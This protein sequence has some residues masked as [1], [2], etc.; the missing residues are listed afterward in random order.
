MF[1]VFYELAYVFD[2]SD[3]PVVLIIDDVD[4]PANKEVL[5]EFLEQLRARYITRGVNDMPAFHSVILSSEKDVRALQGKEIPEDKYVEHIPWDISSDFDLDLSLPCEGIKAMLDDYES[6]HNCGMNTEEM[7]KL[8]CE[9]TKG[10]PGLVSKIC[11]IIDTKISKEKGLSDA[12]TKS[13]FEEAVKE[14]S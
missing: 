11:Y 9:Y 1:S 3:R 5:C 7:A 8:I 13:G 10:Y 4:R 2:K 12:W 6:E 14:I